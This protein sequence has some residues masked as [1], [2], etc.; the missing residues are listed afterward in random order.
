MIFDDDIERYKDM[1]NPQNNTILH[2][3]F[4][5]KHKC[6]FSIFV[7]IFCYREFLIMDLWTTFKDQLKSK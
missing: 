1:F 7:F 5:S 3:I 6:S 2:G 4:K